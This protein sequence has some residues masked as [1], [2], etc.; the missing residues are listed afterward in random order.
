[1][2]EYD[3][4]PRQLLT[5]PLAARYLGLKPATLKDWRY[6]GRGPR[7]LKQSRSV[8]YCQGDL[9][10]WLATHVRDPARPGEPDH[11]ASRDVIVL[12]NARMKRPRRRP[13][14][15]SLSM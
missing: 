9:D 10:A 13:R 12:A 11:A 8:R 1:M 2:R 3:F 7:Y 6:R 4:P 15:L 14:E 5:T